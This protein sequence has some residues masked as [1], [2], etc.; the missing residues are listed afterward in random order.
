M[1][2]IRKEIQVKRLGI[3]EKHVFDCVIETSEDL[4]SVDLN[5]VGKGSM[6]LCIANN[7]LYCKKSN[8]VWV[9]VL[10]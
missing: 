7:K 8:N 10:V 2:V 9:E 4:A 6:A 1:A 5:D 3:G